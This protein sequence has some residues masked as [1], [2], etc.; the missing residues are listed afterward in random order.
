MTPNEYV[1]R[2]HG[3]KLSNIYD[4]LREGRVCGAYK[5]G[6]NWFI[7]D[8]A[9]IVYKPRPKKHRNISDDLFDVLK[10]LLNNQYIDEKTIYLSEEDFAERVHLLKEQQLVVEAESPKNGITSTGLRLTG[11]GIKL[12]Q[13]KKYAIKQK[14]KVFIPNDIRINLSL[15]NVG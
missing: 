14:L 7:P 6:R 8:G 1:D 13:N 12:A 4:L 3:G 15:I 2:Y 10:A 11:S 5:E 9:K